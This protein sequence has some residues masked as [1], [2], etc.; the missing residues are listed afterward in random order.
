MS[1]LNHASHL[2]VY[3]ND[4]SALIVSSKPSIDSYIAASTKETHRRRSFWCIFK[5]VDNFI[6]YFVDL[7][8]GMI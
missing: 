8:E 2:F 4:K 7:P 3:K 5:E 6:F 1:P